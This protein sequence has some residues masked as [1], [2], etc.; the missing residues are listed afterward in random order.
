LFEARLEVIKAKSR[1]KSIASYLKPDICTR[2]YFEIEFL[3][4]YSIQIPYPDNLEK[5][6]D[7]IESELLLEISLTRR[8]IDNIKFYVKDY[9]EEIERVLKKIV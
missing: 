3:N 6:P 5:L 7:A 2:K 9:I 1:N 4:G 8:Q